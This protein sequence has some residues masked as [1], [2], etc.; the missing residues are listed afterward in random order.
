[1]RLAQSGIGDTHMNATETARQTGEVARTAMVPLG[2]SGD[3]PRSGTRIRTGLTL[4]HDLVHGKLAVETGGNALRMVAGGCAGS[5]VSVSLD[6]PG[7]DA[8]GTRAIAGVSVCVAARAVRPMSCDLRLNLN[9]ADGQRRLHDTILLGQGRREIRFDTRSIT[10][11]GSRP[12]S[13]W[14]DLILPEPREFDV[15]LA[16]LVARYEPFPR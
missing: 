6:V 9:F 2:H 5:Y 15:T 11:D 16:D 14:V 4:F 10:G 3:A 8:P 12:I 7:D 13:A 1:M